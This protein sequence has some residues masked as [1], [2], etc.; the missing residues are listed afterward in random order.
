[1]INRTLALLAVLV[2]AAPATALCATVTHITAAGHGAV[3]LDPNEATI[4]ATVQTNADR[5]AE[6]TAQNSAIYERVTA[7]LTASGIARSDVTLAYYN[8]G[9][10]PRPAEASQRAPGAIYGYT[11]TRSFDVN[12]R[13]IAKAGSVVDTLSHAGATNIDNISFGVADPTRARSEATSRAIAE[14][15]TRA[16]AAARAAGLRITGIESIGLDGG[17]QIVRPGIAADV[18]SM[19]AAA[20]T[21]FD[22]GSI[23]I[24][25][26]VTIV[27]LA[28]P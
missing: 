22:S 10:N 8:M 4:R 9:Y 15:R 11:V 18:F 5:A 12:V 20:P 2:L 28:Q 27:F 24:S 21:T 26:D 16:E 25:A 3:S 6:A 7:A 19:K 14:A 17:G 1:M 13:D 23:T